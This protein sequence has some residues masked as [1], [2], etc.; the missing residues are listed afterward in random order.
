MCV[1]ISCLSKHTQK[2]QAHFMVRLYEP[3]L[4]GLR[5]PFSPSPTP[6]SLSR[7]VPSWNVCHVRFLL[8]A[9]QPLIWPLSGLW[10]FSLSL[11]W[12]SIRGKKRGQAKALFQDQILTKREELLFLVVLAFPKASRTGLAWMIW[13]S[14]DPCP[15][16]KDRHHYLLFTKKRS[17]TLKRGCAILGEPLHRGPWFPLRPDNRPWLDLPSHQRRLCQCSRCWQNTGWLSSCSQSSQLQ[18]L[19]YR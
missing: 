17:G 10:L 11:K 14:R 15:Q 1:D 19:H 2:Y 5:R 8:W 7:K 6:L 9:Y 16:N 3:N 18:I 4:A 12:H 13:S